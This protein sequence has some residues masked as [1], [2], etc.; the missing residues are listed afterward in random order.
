MTARTE[1]A[2]RE[3]HRLFG[4]ALLF[5]YLCFGYALEAL[6][7][8]KTEAFVLDAIRREFWSLAHF[9]G[10]LLGLLNVVY[11]AHAEPAGLSAA[12]ARRASA[13]LLAGSALLPLGFFFGGLIHHEGE[14]G[15]G[16]FLVP[17][18]AIFVIAAVA[19]QGAA[20]WRTRAGAGPRTGAGAN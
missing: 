13:S 14:P 12:G 16:I 10:A 17:F 9:H 15:A 1:S 7:G 3:R 19:A 18:A 11:S 20:A 2:L 8:F 6:E 5:A 4:W